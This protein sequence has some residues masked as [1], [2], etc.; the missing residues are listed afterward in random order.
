[1]QIGS[2]LRT[3]ALSQA[4]YNSVTGCTSASTKPRHWPEAKDLLKSFLSVCL[5]PALKVIFKLPQ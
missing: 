4:V 1:M 5:V 3:P 2:V